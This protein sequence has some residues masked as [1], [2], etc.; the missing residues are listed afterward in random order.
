MGE[1]YLL[2]HLSGIGLEVTGIDIS[3]YI[4]EYLKKTFEDNSIKAKLVCGDITNINLNED[5]FD[6]ITCLDVLEHIPGDDLLKAV[7]NIKK[8]LR[9]AT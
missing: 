9:K 6:L 7:K 8:L 2:K 4:I 1:G 5:S 3:E